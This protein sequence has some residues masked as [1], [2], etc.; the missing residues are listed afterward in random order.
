MICKKGCY[1]KLIA[2]KILYDY[3]KSARRGKELSQMETPK[4]KGGGVKWIISL[5]IKKASD[6]SEVIEGGENEIMKL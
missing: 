4:L 5:A 3:K 2:A 1:F 6:N